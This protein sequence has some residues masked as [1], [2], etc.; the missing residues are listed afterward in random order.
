VRAERMRLARAR[1]QRHD[2]MLLMTLALAVLTAAE[3]SARTTAA[4]V[5]AKFL[6]FLATHAMSDD[7]MLLMDQLKK[8]GAP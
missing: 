7:T 8:L 5:E 1:R 3:S 2:W 6:A 4:D